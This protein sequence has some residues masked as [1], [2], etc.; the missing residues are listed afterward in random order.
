MNIKIAELGT[1]FQKGVRSN[2]E[3]YIYPVESMTG[4]DDRLFIVC[5]GMG[6]HAA[7]EVASKLACETLAKYLLPIHPEEEINPQLLAAFDQVQTAFD[8]YM[9]ENPDSLGMG[10]T[11]VLAMI[12]NKG[13]S[14]MHCGDSRLYHFR[15]GEI[16]WMSS[17]HSL[18]NE[19]VQKGLI[20]PEEAFGHPRSNVITR[21]IQGASVQR[22][23]P[24]LHLLDDIEGGDYLFMCTDGVTNSIND[25]DL[26]HIFGKNSS[27]SEKV[28]TITSL[29]DRS[30]KDNYSAFI[31]KIG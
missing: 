19:W 15:N 11:L 6:G 25:K 12:H 24:D 16:M 13:I 29:C 20:T 26:C 22:V 1:I 3:D 9:N 8:N 10:T 23:K 30:S 14:V 17:D 21:A 18:V 7:G 5:D 2:M 27:T 4:I 28:T 31:I